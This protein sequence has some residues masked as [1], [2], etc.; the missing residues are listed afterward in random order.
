MTCDRSCDTEAGCICAE[1]AQ[2]L[3]GWPTVRRYPRSAADAFPMV[4]A[5]AIEGYRASLLERLW[6]WLC[7]PTP[8]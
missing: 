2:T 1:R 7:A 5:P 4:R 8:F 6:R 3:S